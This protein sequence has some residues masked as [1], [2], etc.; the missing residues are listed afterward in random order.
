MYISFFTAVAVCYD[1]TVGIRVTSKWPMV[2][3]QPVKLSV[4]HLG[5]DSDP[6]NARAG[7]GFASTRRIMP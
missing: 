6:G 7:K 4:Q 1:G 2:G 5:C 3:N